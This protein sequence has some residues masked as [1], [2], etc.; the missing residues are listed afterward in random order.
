MTYAISRIPTINSSHFQ[1]KLD[2]SNPDVIVSR[3]ELEL[4]FREFYAWMFD[5]LSA[6]NMISV[7]ELRDTAGLDTVLSDYVYGFDKTCLAYASRL[8]AKGEYV[9]EFHP[10][11]LKRIV[12]LDNVMEILNPPDR[13]KFVKIKTRIDDLTKGD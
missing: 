10:I 8:F 1:S 6:G 4:K 3:D 5:H 11:F 13:I 9:L 12:D 7:G 2:T